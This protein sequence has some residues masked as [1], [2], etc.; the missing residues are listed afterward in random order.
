MVIVFTAQICMIYISN[1]VI[2]HQILALWDF[3]VA[4][5]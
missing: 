2:M 3:F 4:K 5:F 1:H